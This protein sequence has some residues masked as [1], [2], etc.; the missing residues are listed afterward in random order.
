MISP[1]NVLEDFE[2]V[3]CVPEPRLVLNTANVEAVESCVEIAAEAILRSRSTQG[4][5]GRQ[6]R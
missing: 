5:G 4:Q 2:A 1:D 3:A 6:R